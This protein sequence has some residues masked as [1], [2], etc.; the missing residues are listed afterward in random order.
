MTPGT[1]VNT[2]LTDISRK[3]GAPHGDCNR[4]SKIEGV[5]RP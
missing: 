3:A 4:T 2:V 5:W 1:M